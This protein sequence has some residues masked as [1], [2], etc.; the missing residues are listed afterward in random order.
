[1]ED[2]GCNIK[3]LVASPFNGVNVTAEGILKKKSKE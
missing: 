3:I 1:M 2:V